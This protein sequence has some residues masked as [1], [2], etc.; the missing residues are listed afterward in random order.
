MRHHFHHPPMGPLHFH[1]G[2]RPMFWRPY[3]RR[4]S[5]LGLIGLAALGYTLLNKN[6]QNQTQQRVYTTVDQDQD[7]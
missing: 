7:W 4:G 6:Q 2:H 1:H 3:H 5:L